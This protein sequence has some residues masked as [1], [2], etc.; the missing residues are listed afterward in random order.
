M[1]SSFSGPFPF[2]LCALRGFA[3]D[4]LSIT[5]NLTIKAIYG[6]VWVAPVVFLSCAGLPRPA[7]EVEVLSLLDPSALLYLRL[8]GAELD[9][10]VPTFVSVATPSKR[11][12]AAAA[13]LAAKS[14]IIGFALLPETR[15]RDQAGR[16]GADTS[17]PPPPPFE[18]ALQGDF[19]PLALSLSLSTSK[20]WKRDGDV[21]R[22][23]EVG[24][25]TDLRL[26]FPRQG[27]LL[28]STGDPGSLIGR[29]KKN[30]R[31]PLPERLAAFK[32]SGFLA[33]F[34]EPINRLGATLLKGSGLFEELSGSLE[35]VLLAGGSSPKSLS[36]KP[37][38]PILIVTIIVLM[39]DP[40]SARTYQPAIRLAWNLIERRLR[41]EDAVTGEA[42]FVREGDRIAISGLTL[43]AS[44][45]ASLI[46]SR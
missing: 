29:A 5:A 12:A 44:A 20:D 2:I 33:W 38:D 35:G 26:A 28:L 30:G 46:L 31:D 24:Q 21:W 43:R 40:E 14:R 8:S 36:A 15:K 17:L 34:P 19:S 9:T 1:T 22:S 45:L 6:I 18:A 41:L 32:S 13:D 39:R 3:R 16:S 11:D 25:T 4:F 10:L 27:L 7:P 42:S 37:D 23:V